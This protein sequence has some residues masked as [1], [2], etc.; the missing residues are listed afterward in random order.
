MSHNRDCI[1]IGMMTGQEIGVLMNSKKAFHYI[2][3][4]VSTKEQLLIFS[5]REDESALRRFQTYTS[6]YDT[7][8]NCLK[9]VHADYFNHINDCKEY[10]RI[11]YEISIT[12]K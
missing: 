3:N 5:L 2:S 6:R 4:T 7:I 10:S 1:I 8:G 9:Q 11:L 12:K